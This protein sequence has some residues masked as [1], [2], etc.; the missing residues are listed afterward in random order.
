M[1]RILLLGLLVA[2]LAFALAST[3]TTKLGSGYSALQDQY[4]LC[5]QNVNNSTIYG[6]PVIQ[7][8]ASVAGQTTCNAL[9][10]TDE[11]TADTP[12]QPGFPSFKVVGLLCTVSS[13][14][15]NDVV[16]TLRSAIADL[17]P[18]VGCT[19]AGTGT[20]QHCFTTD[21][22]SVDVA[23]GATV[24]VKVVTT[25]DLSAQDFRCEVFTELR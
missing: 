2:S 20:A 17:T 18:S 24:A 19:V 7:G 11:G 21:T 3:P 16:F 8:G 6:G 9:D 10:D 4:V 25:E 15:S 13:D 23:S 22:T 12:L 5:G 1:G 14:A